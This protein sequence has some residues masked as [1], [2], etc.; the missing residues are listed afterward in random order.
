VDIHTLTSNKMTLQLDSRVVSGN[1]AELRKIGGDFAFAYRIS[2]VTMAYE[3]PEKL[4]LETV[5]LGRHIYYTINGNRK[6]TVAPFVHKVEDITG[7]PGKKQTLLDQGLLPPE[8]LEDYT[9][10]FLRRDGDN[11]VF[12][13]RPKAAGETEH[14]VV[15]IEPKTKVT[16]KRETYDRHGQ[17]EKYLLYKNPQEVMPGVYI[18]TRVEVYNAEN[19]LAGVTAYSNIRVNQP[20]NPSLFKVD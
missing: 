14:S 15:W 6:V 8:Q 12:D 9:A 11:Y 13:L 1:Q 20:I 4:H 10:T 19:K 7:A 5:I 18:P 17:L 16:V 3:Q 2:H